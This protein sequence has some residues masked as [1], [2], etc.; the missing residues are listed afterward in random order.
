MKT[1]I[2]IEQEVEIKTIR[3]EVA[4]RY[5]EDDI[6]NSFPL[7][8]GD[9]W[10]ADVD[11]D[12]GRITGWPAGQTGEMHMKVCD[13]GTYTLFDQHGNQIAKHENDYVPHGIVPGIYGDY[14]ELKINA[15]GIITNW[16]K[17]P[18]ADDFFV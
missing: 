7:R 16:P 1:K 14:I 13:E 2:K 10:R 11:V 12:T 8:Q 6:P 9:M 5:E 4:V 18:N 15:D 3:I 17:K